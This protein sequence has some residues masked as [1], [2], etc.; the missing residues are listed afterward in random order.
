M[1]LLLKNECLFY[2]ITKSDSLHCSRL[3]FNQTWNLFSNCRD[4][5]LVFLSIDHLHIIGMSDMLTSNRINLICCYDFLRWDDW[6]WWGLNSADQAHWFSRL[7]KHF[8]DCDSVCWI[9][10]LNCVDC[11]YECFCRIYWD[12]L[13]R[14]RKQFAVF[15]NYLGNLRT[16]LWLGTYTTSFSFSL[17]GWWSFITSLSLSDWFWKGLDIDDL[18]SISLLHNSNF[19]MLRIN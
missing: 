6:C 2:K 15:G 18:K 12:N 10:D 5:N 17:G 7:R 13:A 11:W 4:V 9:F 1:G 8:Y 14:L 19:L 16:S 3:D